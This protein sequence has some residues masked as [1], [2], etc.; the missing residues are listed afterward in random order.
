MPR[1][2]VARVASGANYAVTMQTQPVN[3]TC[4]VANGTGMVTTAN[5]TNV[6]AMCI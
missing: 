3:Q 5:I 4:T 6:A 2:D 1:H